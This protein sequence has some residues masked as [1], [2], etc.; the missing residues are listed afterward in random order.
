MFHVIVK[1]MNTLTDADA[2]AATL[3]EYVERVGMA[4]SSGTANRS[5]G[6]MLGWLL[7][8]DPPEQSISQLSCA[9]RT[10]PGN[11]SSTATELVR[12]GL[13]ERV[14]VSGSRRV[15]Y[16]LRADAWRTALQTRR[17]RASDLRVLAEEGLALLEES[18]FAR[19]E[20]LLSMHHLFAFLEAEFLSA[21]LRYNETKG[22][23]HD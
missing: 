10:G 8:S 12:A 3:A 16:R 19:R 22:F 5:G 11:V 18:S 14:G 13:I 21:P 17:E 1:C 2:A 20:R 7:V 23:D 9:L 4:L 15:H 6:R